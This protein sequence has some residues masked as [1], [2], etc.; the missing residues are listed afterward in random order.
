MSVFVVVLCGTRWVS[1]SVQSVLSREL[2][3]RHRQLSEKEDEMSKDKNL[4]FCM[5]ELQYM[6]N[7]DGLEPGQRSALE[8][9]ERELR[10]LWRKPNPT[11]R[12]IF[13]VVRNVAEAIINNFVG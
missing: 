5:D 6:Q 8:K 1:F 13:K 10:R 4:Q 9:A 3:L 11:R 12:E 2:P 7:R